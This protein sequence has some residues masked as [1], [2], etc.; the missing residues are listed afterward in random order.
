MKVAKPLGVLLLSSLS[1]SGLAQAQDA[2]RGQALAERWCANC[3]VIDTGAAGNA[4]QGP[5]PLPTTARNLSAGQL[6]AFLS[7]PHGKMPD[8]SLTRAEIGDLIAYIEQ[9]R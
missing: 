6:R 8:L 7:H 2:V 3:H 4:Q 5:P 9:L 1:W